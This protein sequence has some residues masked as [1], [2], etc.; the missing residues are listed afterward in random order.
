MRIRDVRIFFLL[1][2]LSGCTAL[3]GSPEGAHTP[4]DR[5]GERAATKVKQQSTNHP[6]PNITINPD[7]QTVTVLPGQTS[8]K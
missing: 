4:A 6:V 7:P 1:F 5:S 3:G 2:L 8:V